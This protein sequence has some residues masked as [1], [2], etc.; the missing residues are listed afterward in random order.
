[1]IR[2][3]SLERRLDARLAHGSGFAPPVPLR[4]ALAL[5]ARADARWVALLSRAR[6]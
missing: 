2:Q 6:A 3:L 1:M 4:D 5:T